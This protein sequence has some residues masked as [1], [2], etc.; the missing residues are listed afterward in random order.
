MIMSDMLKITIYTDGACSGNPGPGGLAVYWTVENG[1][2]VIDREL[3]AEPKKHTTNN[4]RELQAVLYALEVAQNLCRVANSESVNAKVI[5]ISDSTYC[6]DSI[7]KGWIDNWKRNNWMRKGAYIPNYKLWK[8]VYKMLHSDLQHED[9]ELRWI[10]GH[11]NKNT[12]ND[13]VDKYAVLACTTQKSYRL[14]MEDFEGSVS[15]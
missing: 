8:E 7:K 2:A 9:L 14:N 4:E 6:I 15:Q 13:L 3:I 10:R 12:G 5:I 1:E 11:Q